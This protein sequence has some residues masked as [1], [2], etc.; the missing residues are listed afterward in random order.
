MKPDLRSWA[1]RSGAALVAALLLALTVLIGPAQAQQP[2]V[3]FLSSIQKMEEMNRADFWSVWDEQAARAEEVINADAG[4][5]ELFA[6]VRADLDGQ[7]V[8]AKA[9]SDAVAAELARLT[10]E[11]DALGPTPEE[12]FAEVADVKELRGE[13]TQRIAEAR[14]LQSRAERTIVRADALLPALARV[15][16]RRFIKRLTT[17]GASPANPPNWLRTV[18]AAQKIFRRIQGE[19]ARVFDDPAG[20]ARLRESAPITAIAFLFAAFIGIGARGLILPLVRRISTGDGGGRARR[21]AISVSTSV[22]RLTALLLVTVAVLVGIQSLDAFGAVGEAFLSGLA[23]GLGQLILVFTLGA[24]FFSPASPQMRVSSLDDQAA[25]RGFRASLFVGAALL[26]DGVATGLRDVVTFPNAASV[27]VTFVTILIGAFG[28][29]RLAFF[30]V[31]PAAA[32]DAAGAAYQCLLALRRTMVGVA[33]AA[34]L[35][36][37]IGYDFAARFLFFPFV[38]SLILI[39][40][41]YLIFYVVSAAVDIRI[42]DRAERDGAAAPQAEDADGEPAPTGQRLRLLPIFT[43][44][45]LIC[46]GAPILAMIWGASVADLQAAYRALSDGLVIG[47]MVFSPVD[48][49]VFALFFAVG[50]M[51]TRSVQKVLKS[52]I[53]PKAGVSEGGAAAIVSGFGYLGVFVAVVVAV[54]AA[55]IDLSSL[56]LVIGALS[57]G[58]GL[59]LQNIVNNFVSGI[60]LL[61]ERPLKPGD[62]IEVGGIHGNV[63]KVNV[64]STE[65]ETFDRSSYIIPN[66]DLIS[67]PVTNYTLS[68]TIGRVIVPVHVGY[69]VDTR[70]VERI[71]LEIG[72]AHS[73]VML[74][75]APIVYFMKFGESALEFELRVIIRNVNWIFAVRSELNHDIAERFRKEGIAIPVPQ[76]DLHIRSMDPPSGRAAEPGG[77]PPPTIEE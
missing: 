33:V 45:L 17:L 59:G 36:A 5:P 55:G 64:R 15:A 44:F 69:G 22:M 42:A 76:R 77:D 53:L 62:W 50:Y 57:V 28:L 19:I 9:I 52:S 25:L 49:F 58:V 65:I 1:G 73:M 54:S 72:R 56:A 71:L 11:L 4:T 68:D 3:D 34:P 39:A 12:G 61:I 48:F 6:A 14:A 8:R 20:R 60:V 16:Q 35:L 51:L 26:L 31:R 63:R 43:G 66:S 29:W 10:K 40:A 18:E 75:P 2:S 7:K 38:R 37:L 74:N 23:S 32:G 13:L 46:A 27:V 21:L 70:R 41:G 30:S 24:A 47:E 67:G